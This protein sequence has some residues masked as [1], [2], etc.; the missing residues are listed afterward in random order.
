MKI[1]VTL[2]VLFSISVL[3][4]MSNV[5]SFYILGNT[6]FNSYSPS[7]LF[8][9]QLE[10][11]SASTTPTV[12]KEIHQQKQKNCN[13]IVGRYKCKRL[14]FLPTSFSSEDEDKVYCE[15]HLAEDTEYLP[16]KE[17]ISCLE[18][19]PPKEWKKMSNLIQNKISFL[20]NPAYPNSCDF[21]NSTSFLKPNSKLTKDTNGILIR[22]KATQLEYDNQPKWN[23]VSFL[24]HGFAYN[25]WV[26]AWNAGNHWTTGVPVITSN[27][28]YRFSQRE[29]GNHWSCFFSPLSSCS[30]DSIQNKKSI[31]VYLSAAGDELATDVNNLCQPYGEY[32]YSTGRCEC[33]DQSMPSR[34]E[35]FAGCAP[36]Q[37]FDFKQH[38]KYLHKKSWETKSEEVKSG[39]DNYFSQLGP[40]EANPRLSRNE[41]HQ[42]SFAMEEENNKLFMAQ[43]KFGFLFVHSQFLWYMFKNSQKKELLDQKL[44]EVGFSFGDEKIVALH[45]RHGDSC[46]DRFLVWKKCFPLSFYIASIK[47]ME[48]KYGKYDKIYISTDDPQVIED[49]KN[50]SDYNFIYQKIDRKIYEDN[51]NKAVDERYDFNTP[52]MVEQIVSDIWAM[53]HCDAFVG[54][55]T[56]SVAW[57]SYELMIA[58]KGF[59]PPFISVYMSMFDKNTMGKLIHTVNYH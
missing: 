46:H 44:K 35:R 8:F 21:P 7:N 28:K 5:F 57:V 31:L 1:P 12:Y 3:I 22:K 43:E 49:T 58:R 50:Y 25:T 55:W 45:V 6:S 19:N 16:S 26:F 56:S 37:N 38:R 17:L 34:E 30:F 23:L 11:I 15:F 20:Q 2:L 13:L 36:Y 18:E 42:S 29:C 41:L 14:H 9:P 39:D 24:H 51:D 54:S 33:F 40:G 52:E 27:N 4:L 32:N 47:K 53:S 48:K 59:Y 10:D